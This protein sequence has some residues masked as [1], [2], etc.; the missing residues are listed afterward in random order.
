MIQ[1]RIMIIIRVQRMLCTYYYYYY[2]KGAVGDT[3]VV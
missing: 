2:F 3:C 1:M